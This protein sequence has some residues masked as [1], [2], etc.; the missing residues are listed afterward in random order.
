[1][2][3]QGLPTAA[4]EDIQS[5]TFSMTMTDALSLRLTGVAGSAENAKLL[6]DSLLGLMSMGKMMLQQQQPGVFDILD[7]GITISSEDVEIQLE[8]SLSGEDIQALREL[9]EAEAAESES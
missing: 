2:P 6:S 9:A 1:M 3:A 5:L 7:R 8:A 4:I